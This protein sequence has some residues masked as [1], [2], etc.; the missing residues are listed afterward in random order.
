MNKQPKRGK[1]LFANQ[2]HAEL[3]LLIFFAAIIPALLATIALFYLIFNITAEQIGIPEAIA[4]NIF[5][6]A[7][8]VMETLVYAIPVSIVVM[9]I[10]AHRITHRIVGPF[11]RIVRELEATIEGT[12]HGHISVRKGDKF[13]PLVDKINRL[14]DRTK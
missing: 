11:D 4:A 5:P 8:K 1:Q 13:W 10:L 14:I 6:A 9:L 2:M 7:Y 3:F 12:R